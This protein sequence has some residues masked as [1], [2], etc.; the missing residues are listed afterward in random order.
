MNCSVEIAY[1][2]IKLHENRLPLDCVFRII[3]TNVIRIVLSMVMHSFV[4]HD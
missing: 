3:A 4:A 1:V 2:L